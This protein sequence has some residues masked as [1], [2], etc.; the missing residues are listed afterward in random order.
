M[1]A[2]NFDMEEV[3]E[4]EHTFGRSSKK[5]TDEN[6]PKRNL[7]AFF[8]WAN[9]LRPEVMKKYPGSS[10]AVVGKELA[11]RWRK[12]TASDK[13]PYEKKASSDSK[14]YHNKLEKYQKTSNYKKHQMKML[15]WKIHVTKKPFRK[16]ENAPKRN[17]SAYMLYGNSVRSQIVKENP[18]LKVT[19][20]MAE[21]SAMFKALGDSDRKHWNEKAAADRKRYETKVARYM[22]T[23]DYQKYAEE[24]DAYK[25]EM[26]EKRNKLMGI[27]KKKKRARSETKNKGPKS[28]SKKKAKKKSS[29]RRSSRKS[30]TPKSS[31]SR[32]VSRKSSRRP[33]RR[34]KAKSPKS[35]KRRSRKRRAEKRKSKAPKAKKRSKSR[36]T[37]RS[38]SR[39]GSRSKSRSTSRS[40]SAPKSKSRSRKA[41]RRKSRKSKKA[42]E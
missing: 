9:D 24:R 33:G 36:S 6:A 30:R 23:S 16:D 22:K 41:S 11:A 29:K 19:E 35:P 25:A 28:P 14:A 31:K 10:M 27:K 21:Q 37:S 38:K 42:T 32:S 3:M 1:V 40:R 20:V 15:A 4:I 17:L 13:A 34:R 2:H 39:S 5:P 26:K 18:D 7:S 8:L 12:A